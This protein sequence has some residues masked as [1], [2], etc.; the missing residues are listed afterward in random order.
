MSPG[1]TVPDFFGTGAFGSTWMGWMGTFPICFRWAAGEPQNFQNHWVT[2]KLKWYY[3]MQLLHCWLRKDFCWMLCHSWIFFFGGGNTEETMRPCRVA[4]KKWPREI[5]VEFRMIV[6]Q[7]V[8]LVNPCLVVPT[9]C[10]V[11][12]KATS[13]RSCAHHSEELYDDEMTVVVMTN[14]HHRRSWWSH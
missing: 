5:L 3:W 9:H 10:S 12:R 8:S 1:G 4:E 7:F 6:V 14:D 13:E 11:A 2:Q